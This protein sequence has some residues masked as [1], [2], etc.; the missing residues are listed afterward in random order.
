MSRLQPCNTTVFLDVAGDLLLARDHPRKRRSPAD[1]WMRGPL[2]P[3]VVLSGAVQSVAE[4]Y[5]RIRNLHLRIPT[6][7]TE[8]CEGH[9]PIALS[10]KEESSTA[11]GGAFVK[12]YRDYFA[13]LVPTSF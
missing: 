8:A 1:G 9:P 5:Y 4:G 2:K 11:G 7:A 6:Q 12:K 10:G 3:V 13:G